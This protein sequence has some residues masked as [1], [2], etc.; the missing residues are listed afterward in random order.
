MLSVSGARGIVGRT[1]TPQVAHAFGLAFGSWLIEHS[2]KA[3]H[4]ITGRD[5]RESGA[6]LLEHGIAGLLSAGC[7][8]TDLGVA[9]TPTV[10]VMVL[11]TR[12]DGALISTASH[13]PIE[14]NG[15]K[16]L[17][18]SG[19][20]P[21]VEQANEIIEGFKNDGIQTTLNARQRRCMT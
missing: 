15:F 17:D 6:E 20:A 9:M 19:A 13:N 8:V 4:V 1:M 7:R 16:C 2:N 18:T 12:A 21:P 5:G 10:G 11:H 3:P 14:W